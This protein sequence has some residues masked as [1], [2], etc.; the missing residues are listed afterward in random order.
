M[1]NSKR[2]FTGLLIAAMAAA[3]MQHSAPLMAQVTSAINADTVL[4]DPDAVG[5]QIAVTEVADPHQVTSL[6]MDSEVAPVG[7]DSCLLPNRASACDQAGDGCSCLAGCDEI[8]GCDACGCASATAKPAATKAGCAD[9]HKGVF[10]AND[11]SYL[12]DPCNQSE[13]FGDCLKL[14]PVAGGKLGTLDVGGQLRLRYHH[15]AGMGRQ[16]GRSGFQDTKNDFLLSRL[17]VYNNWKINNDVRVYA[18]GIFADATANSAYIPRPI[19]R[20]SADI[21]NLFVDL[22]LTD[23]ASVRIG[24]QELLFGSQRVVS[25]LDWANTRRTFEGVR[26]TIQVGDW[27]IDPFFTNLVPVTAFDFDEADYDQSF[28]GVYASGK[29]FGGH[30]T[31][32]YY[33]G[34][35]NDIQ[36]APVTT[37]FELH[38]FGGRVNGKLA[39]GPLMFD[40]EGAYQ[41]GKQQGLGLDHRAGF[42]TAGLGYQF[43]DVAWKPT[44][45]TYYDYA[46]GNDAGG[47]FNRY[48]Q[49][50]PLAHKYLGFIDAAARS[51]ISSPNA[52]L[53]MSPSKKMKLLAWYYYLGA[54]EKGDVI[55]GVAVP[56]NQNLVDDDFGNELDLVASYTIGPRSDILFGYSHLWRGDKIIGTNDADF[57]YSQYTLNF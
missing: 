45:W 52:L 5:S 33:L 15:E 56:S 34:Y 41:T 35:D 2:R 26:G 49:L 19:D 10:Y 51:N 57:F 1:S 20:N 28:Y 47:S 50:F 6:V 42:F 44:L 4:S 48:N 21:L 25:P 12:K 55:P 8:G 53:T 7:F 29:G 39:N 36:G 23:N 18:E 24:R 11:F 13:C 14:M 32:L 3:G 30:N 40:V 16:A 22:Q 46:S 9:S 54:D 17:R 31:D 38:T 43:K 27:T 37:N